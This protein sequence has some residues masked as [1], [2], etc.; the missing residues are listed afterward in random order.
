MQVGNIWNFIK[1]KFGALFNLGLKMK[2]LREETG[3]FEY[4]Q[5]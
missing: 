2:S 4:E 5:L 1:Q 3:E